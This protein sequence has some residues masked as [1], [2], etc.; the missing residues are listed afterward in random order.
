MNVP[1]NS[2]WKFLAQQDISQDQTSFSLLTVS[3]N[4]AVRGPAIRRPNFCPSKEHGVDRKVNSPLIQLRS[5]VLSSPYPSILY[6]SLYPTPVAPSHVLWHDFAI[7]LRPYVRV[8]INHHSY[9]E[10]NVRYL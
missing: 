9:R 6:T 7:E 1:I 8:R 4:L 5:P 3:K 2:R 10:L